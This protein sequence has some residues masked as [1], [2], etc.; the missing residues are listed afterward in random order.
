MIRLKVLDI[1]KEKGITKYSVFKYMNM[2][3]Q[4][5]DKMIRNETK[6][7]KYSNIELLCDILKCTPNDLFEITDDE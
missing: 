4:N 2:S 3:Y 6:S 5:F 1:I 7:I